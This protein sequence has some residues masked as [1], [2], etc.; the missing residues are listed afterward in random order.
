MNR[1]SNLSGRKDLSLKDMTRICIGKILPEHGFR[2]I[3]M[4][5]LTASLAGKL[6]MYTQRK[7]EVGII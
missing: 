3:S 6:I 1:S 2:V 7:R 4:G 5:I